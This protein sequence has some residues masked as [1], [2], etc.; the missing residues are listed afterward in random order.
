MLFLSR[1]YI[2][3]RSITL[4]LGLRH[5]WALTKDLFEWL[6]NADVVNNEG[7]SQK[8]GKVHPSLLFTFAYCTLSSHQVANRMQ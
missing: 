1:I 8:V 5:P 3:Q 2:D 6:E 7:G 4:E